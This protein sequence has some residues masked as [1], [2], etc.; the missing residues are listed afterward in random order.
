[1]ADLVA[2]LEGI[3][4]ALANA[5]V[6]FAV[7]GGLAVAIHGHVR[8]T[9]DIDLLLLTT[10]ASEALR[11]LAGIGFD[12]P[13]LPMTFGAG[14]HAERRVQRVSKA[15]DKELVTVDLI[16]V[17]PTF[18]EVWRGRQN[19]ER[20]SIT[21]PVV[22]RAGLIAMKRIAGRPQDLADI[23]ALEGLDERS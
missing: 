4:A 23:A 2:E 11:V 20:G 15:G 17:E 21:L 8:A 12:L 13:A 7:C 3:A 16:F 10:S 18:P 22:S 9:R 5:Q 19:F 14:T 6:E 1:M